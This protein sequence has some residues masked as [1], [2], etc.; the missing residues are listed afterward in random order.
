ML[1]YLFGNK[2]T[3]N[4]KTL[5]QNRIKIIQKQ[6]LKVEN[7]VCIAVT[8]SGKFYKGLYK[9]EPV[10]VKVKTSILNVFLYLDS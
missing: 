10:S 3:I 7:K 8:G 1:G 4:E 5:E 2:T 9:N 6:D